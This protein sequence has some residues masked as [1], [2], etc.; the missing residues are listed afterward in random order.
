V[1]HELRASRLDDRER[2]FDPR[3]RRREFPASALDAREARERLRLAVRVADALRDLESA[4][5]RAARLRRVARRMGV[6]LADG[7]QG[8]DSPS[9]SATA[10]KSPSD[11]SKAAS[12]SA[13][14]SSSS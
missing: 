1:A 12:A 6:D 3:L 8:G 2:G 7:D 13:R 14:R 4:R 11:S 9:G 10:R 5:E